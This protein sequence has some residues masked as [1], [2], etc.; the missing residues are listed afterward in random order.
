MGLE[1]PF[2]GRITDDWQL[3]GGAVQSPA[4][5][6]AGLSLSRN[7]PWEEQGLS[8]RTWDTSGVPV[9]AAVDGQVQATSLR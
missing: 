9:A 8:E 1:S 6:H 3:E 2:R 7:M 5:V 4:C